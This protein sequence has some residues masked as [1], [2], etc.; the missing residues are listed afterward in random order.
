MVGACN[1][2]SPQPLTQMTVSSLQSHRS[3]VGIY[4]HW[5]FYVALVVL[6]SY[7]TRVTGH[8]QLDGGQRME[9]RTE[10]CPALGTSGTLEAFYPYALHADS[11][12]CTLTLI[13]MGRQKTMPSAD[14]ATTLVFH[15]LPEARQKHGH[16]RLQQRIHSAHLYF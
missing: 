5:Y 13:M 15:Y 9:L 6:L 11:T 2:A 4:A 3:K 12:L 1:K 10:M 14:R 7:T 16:S 8:P